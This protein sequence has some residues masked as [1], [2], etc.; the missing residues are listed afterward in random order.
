MLRTNIFFE[1]QTLRVLKTISRKNKVS[2]GKLVRTAV[3]EKYVE[4]D[5]YEARKKAIEETLRIRPPV[6]KTPIDY[7]EL[8]NYGR[9][10]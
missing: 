6:S 5:P 9:K 4:K 1:D 8:I 10:Y 3:R 7:K 2:V